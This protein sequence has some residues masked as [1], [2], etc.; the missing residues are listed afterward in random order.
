MPTS[1]EEFERPLVSISI[2]SHRHGHMLPSLLSDLN[3]LKGARAEVIL[4]LN[5]P[6]QVALASSYNFPVRVIRNTTEKGFGENHNAAFAVAQG[7]YFAVVNPDLRCPRLDFG[8]LCGMFDDSSVGVVAPV[9]RSSVGEL[10]DSA[11]RFPSVPT[12]MRRAL[13]KIREPEYDINLGPTPVDWL[14]GMFMLFRSE[15]FAKVNGFD[16]RYFMYFEDVDI[17]SRLWNEGWRIFLQPAYSV[18][19]DAQRA[20]HRQWQHLRWH[21][22]S[23]MRYFLSQHQRNS[24][25][26]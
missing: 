4:T 15:A 16:E 13:F 20:S 3:E 25:S 21:V 24:A 2:V 12:L 26:S 10:Q 7:R 8:P 19:H 9:V 22:L 14:A 23:A 5:V 11:R 6:E 18:I 17:C 1:I